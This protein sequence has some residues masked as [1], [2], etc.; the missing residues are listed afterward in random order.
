MERCIHQHLPTDTFIELGD[1]KFTTFYH[2][3]KE[4]T[5]VYKELYYLSQDR[6][7]ASMEEGN[8]IEP[9]KVVC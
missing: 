1:K 2:E 7:Q 4:W 8:K 9:N 6:R 5:E 3:L